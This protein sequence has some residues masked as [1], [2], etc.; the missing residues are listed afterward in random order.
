MIVHNSYGN[1]L[2]HWKQVFIVDLLLQLVVSNAM[3]W[4]T[5]AE[6]RL[7]ASTQIVATVLKVDEC[8]EDSK[9]IFLHV[10]RG[11]VVKRYVTF[12]FLTLFDRQFTVHS[13]A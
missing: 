12:E 2:S 5:A 10:M 7:L 8:N 1:E 11:R 13:C 9:H 4:S 6:G 3:I